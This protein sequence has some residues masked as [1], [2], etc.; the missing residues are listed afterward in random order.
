MP[1][2][3]GTLYIMY[4]NEIMPQTS[5]ETHATFPGRLSLL[6]PEVL[7]APYHGWIH[8]KIV[9]YCCQLLFTLHHKALTSGKNWN[10]YTINSQFS[11]DG[12]IQFSMRA[13]MV[14]MASL[15]GKWRSWFRLGGK[16]CWLHVVTKLRLQVRQGPCTQFPQPRLA[17]ELH[18]S[19]PCPGLT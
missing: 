9:T 19:Q 13:M 2:S 7:P 8:W 16:L 17:P 18:P 6:S 15:W 11:R 10:K 4:S 5:I 3:A 14:D 1:N 12:G